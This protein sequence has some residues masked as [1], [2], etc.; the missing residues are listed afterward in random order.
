MTAQINLATPRPSGNPANQDGPHEQH[1]DIRLRNATLT[2]VE[3]N[4][5]MSSSGSFREALEEGQTS[6]FNLHV[7]III[8]AG[9]G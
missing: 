9:R 5:T 6:F 4:R 1:A 3:K 7:I 2:L 8:V